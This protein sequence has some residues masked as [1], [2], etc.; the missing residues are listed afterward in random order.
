MNKA[1]LYAR[2]NAMQYQ[3]S[4]SILG[5]YLPRLSWEGTGE[6]VVDIGCGTSNVLAAGMEELTSDCTVLGL[7]ISP[8]MVQFA[9]DR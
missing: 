2:F 8:K 6:M 3:H 4:Q 5:Q 7:D 1:D 9:E